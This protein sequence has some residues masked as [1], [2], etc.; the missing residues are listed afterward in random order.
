MLYVLKHHCPMPLLFKKKNQFPCL[1]SDR[2][3]EVW[4]GLCVS[5]LQLQSCVLYCMTIVTLKSGMGTLVPSS[6][7]E[8]ISCACVYICV[9]TCAYVSRCMCVHVCAYACL[10]AHMCGVHVCSHVC[11]RACVCMDACA[12]A[13]A[14]AC[15]LPLIGQKI[16]LIILG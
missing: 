4:L 9:H 13:Q 11:V 2:P 10:H 7:S 15:T 1:S 5:V 16:C 6:Q 8:H 3:R 14:Y 12:C